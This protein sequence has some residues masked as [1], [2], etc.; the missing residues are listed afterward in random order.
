[1]LAQDVPFVGPEIQWWHLSPLITLVAGALL[2]LVVFLCPVYWLFMISFKT[3]EE[4]FAGF[5]PQRGRG[6]SAS[7]DARVYDHWVATGR[8]AAAGRN[9]RDLDRLGRIIA[10][11]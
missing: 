8:C 7:Y 2:L 9:H 10:G 6:Y 1:M 4:I 5:D 11:R 3:P